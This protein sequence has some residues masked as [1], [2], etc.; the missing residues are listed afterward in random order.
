MEEQKVQR[1]RIFLKTECGLHDDYLYIAEKIRFLS[2]DLLIQADE[3]LRMSMLQSCYSVNLKEDGPD[4]ALKKQCHI[5][6]ICSNLS[7]THPSDTPVVSLN[8]SAPPNPHHHEGHG[9]TEVP[10]SS[11]QQSEPPAK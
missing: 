5:A 9:I 11:V 4:A 3:K 7:R 6:I 2:Y 10:H 1:L 8:T